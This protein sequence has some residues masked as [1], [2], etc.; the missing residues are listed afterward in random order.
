MGHRSFGRKVSKSDSFS[1]DGCCG[2]SFAAA[3]DD[4][5]NGLCKV[6]QEQTR[7]VAELRRNLR[8]QVSSKMGELLL[9]GYTMLNAYCD[10]CSGI[11]M[12]DRQGVRVCVTCDLLNAQLDPTTATTGGRIV[13]EIALDASDEIH[14]NVAE[15]SGAVHQQL[16][17]SSKDVPSVNETL[18]KLKKSKEAALKE[19]Y[20]VGLEKCEQKRAIGDGHDTEARVM[21]KL[22]LKRDP[23]KH[24]VVRR[25]QWSGVESALRAVD[26]KL[27]WCSERLINT[28]D[29]EEIVTLHKAIRGGIEILECCSSSK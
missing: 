13:A 26:E 19:L 5:M 18:S 25:S 11:L 22:K 9:R 20:K 14:E 7:T 1:K 24:T 21:N 23:A 28:E 10:I 17:D 16:G 3:E 12:E 6:T 2:S 29:L 27:R 15:M 4:K 8:D